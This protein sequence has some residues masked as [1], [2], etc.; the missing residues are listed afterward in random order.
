MSKKIKFL[1]DENLSPLT[2]KF[3]KELGFDCVRITDHKDYSRNDKDVAAVAIKEQRI[4]L[5][6]DLDF[7]EIYHF[8]SSRS[9][10][11]WI[12]R[13]TDLTVE[14]V[15]HRL[16]QFLKSQAFAQ[17]DPSGLVILEDRRHRVRLE[18]N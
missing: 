9:Y 16:K 2:V 1:L 10:G 6:T 12:M 11:V 18:A 17:L 5:T 3:L 14:S 15:N 7:G 13:L 8:W 4:L